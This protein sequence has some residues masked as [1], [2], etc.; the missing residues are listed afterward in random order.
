MSLG[1]DVAKLETRAAQLEKL[2]ATSTRE[3]DA[4]QELEIGYL[5]M[6]RVLTGIRSDERL[7]AAARRLASGTQTDED[8]AIMKRS[9]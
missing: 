9:A 4:L 3:R 6:L 7:R 8:L 1:T 2:C 5:E